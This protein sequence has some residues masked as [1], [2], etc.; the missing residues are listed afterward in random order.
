LCA[1]AQA[2][3][4]ALMH[5]VDVQQRRLAMHVDVRVM[6]MLLLLNTAIWLVMLM[7]EKYLLPS[8]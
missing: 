1:P 2:E 6:R 3:N 4:Q 7:L 8:L 5:L